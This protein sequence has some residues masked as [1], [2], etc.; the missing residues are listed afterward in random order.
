MPTIVQDCP[1]CV[2]QSMTFDILADVH[3]GIQDE[4]VHRFE[5]CAVCRRCY[6]PTLMRLVLEQYGAR[7]LF[8]ESG[9]ITKSKAFDVSV[10]FRFGGYVNLADVSAKPA[11]ADLPPDITT[12]FEEAS[13]CLAVN[14]PNASSAMFRLCLDIAT[15]S[16]LP[17]DAEP[18]DKHTRRNLAPRL[19]WLFENAVL[20][21][22]LKSLSAAV[23][24]NGDEGVHEG[25]MSQLDAEDIYD[26]AFALLDR[27]YSEPARIEAAAKRRAARRGQ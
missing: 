9:S 2:A 25:S 10:F 8:K 5:V 1:R 15:K 20:P 13:R 22:D 27:L 26:F 12:I 4:W 6:R 7:E 21:S 3:V 17:D 23:K 24:D 16:L 18:L 11:P 19:R 14:C